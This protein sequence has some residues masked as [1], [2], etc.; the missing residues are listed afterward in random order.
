MTIYF[1]AGALA[2]TVNA[3]VGNFKPSISVSENLTQGSN[4]ANIRKIR[5][6]PYNRRICRK[7]ISVVKEVREAY[8]NLITQL[9]IRKNLETTMLL[10]KQ[11]R[12]MVTQRYNKKGNDIT[13]LNQSQKNYVKIEKAYLDNRVN[14][15]KVKS[16]LNAT[17]GIQK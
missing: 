9:A 1:A 6:T 2:P 3:A 16:N 14:I 12:D 11:R 5:T 4:I 7:W 15:L 10:T 13:T 17:T 8:L